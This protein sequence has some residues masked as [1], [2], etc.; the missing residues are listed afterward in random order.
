MVRPDGNRLLVQGR[1]P[2]RVGLAGE[3]PAAVVTGEPRSRPRVGGKSPTPERGVKGPQT[4]VR[5]SGGEQWSGPQCES[6][7]LAAS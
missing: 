7:N 5:L 2:R 6:V 4:A 1:V 3:S